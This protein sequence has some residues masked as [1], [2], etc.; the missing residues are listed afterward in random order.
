VCFETNI[1]TNATDWARVDAVELYDHIGDDGSSF[2]RF[3][4]AN[5]AG[6]PENAEVVSALS[7]ALRAGWRKAIPKHLFPAQTQMAMQQAL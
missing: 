2:D 4:N 7:A 3:E 5:V 1:C 6:L